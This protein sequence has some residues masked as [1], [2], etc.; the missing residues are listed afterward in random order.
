MG[1]PRSNQGK[2]HELW[3]ARWFQRWGLPAIIFLIAFL[4][5]ADYPVSRPYLWAERS[6][7]F[8]NAILNGD[9][10][11]TNQS[12]HPGV[13]V[14]WLSGLG[15]EIYELLEGEI[16][17][18]Q[19]F[20]LAPAR[21]GL[22]VAATQAELLP[23]AL[24]ISLGIAL[25]YPLLSRL[26]GRAIA[27]VAA[28]FLALDP[29]HITYSKV[30]HLDALLAIFMILSALFLLNYLKSGR[31]PDLAFSGIFAGL[32]FLTKSP[33]IFLVPYSAL[34]V[35][36]TILTRTYSGRE[37]ITIHGLSKPI[38]QIIRIMLAW[39]GLAVL[40]FI[41]LYPAMWFE[42]QTVLQRI[43]SEVALHTGTVH[44]NPVYFWGRVWEQDPGLIFYVATIG[45]KTTAVTLPLI[46]AAVIFGIPYRK[47]EQGCVLWA[48]ITYIIFF[49]LQMGIGNWK[50]LAYIAPAFPA[51]SFVAAFGLVWTVDWL[52]QLRRWQP[53]QWQPLALIGLVLLLQA[54]LVLHHHPYYGT[55]NNLLLGGSRTAKEVLPLQDQA[56]GMD[57]AAQFLN[58]LPHGQAKLAAVFWR[59]AK[60]FEREFVGRTT[61]DQ[62][63]GAAYRIYD[64]NSVLRDFHGQEAW[65]DRWLE[66]Q[67]NT[68]LFT[69]NFD[70]LTYV[71]VYG[72]LP[73]DP[74]PDG[75]KFEVNA[76]IGDQ[77]T[78]RQAR[79]NKD[80]LAPGE[81]LVVVL[82][83]EA[84]GL[85]NGNYTVF[86]HLIATE[87]GAM[88]QQD[89][90][91]LFGSRPTYTWQENEVLEDPY[92][93][94]VDETL[95]LGEYQLSVGMYDSETTAR[96]PAFDSEGNRLPEDRIIIG[97][98]NLVAP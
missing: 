48:L 64:L 17:Y 69:A 34:I 41:L 14:M 86:N 32:S 20:A 70:G 71:W 35:T 60:L 80:E 28:L 63:S 40:V 89:N 93:L 81:P 38:W 57:L 24:A 18:D 8:S 67:Q 45:W 75:P 94:A 44:E 96:I 22:L 62:N 3:Q 88:D 66:D 85:V 27:L 7:R 49:T 19:F 72:D 47:R 83:W 10:A 59:N 87:G 55:H 84:N 53:G 56:E 82:T 65:R 9:L 36:I 26:A 79:L 76:H 46:A 2:A 31:W 50:Q 39:L 21:P 91:P 5:R 92:Y 54:V 95:P 90:I 61:R 37:A 73:S 98:V 78:L 29:Y 43:Q 58:E 11:E 12:S 16:P 4:P 97:T 51:L 30:I 74:A 25:T 1:E 33:A 52:S 77:I 6:Y 15:I 23:L 42:P 68:P 13:P